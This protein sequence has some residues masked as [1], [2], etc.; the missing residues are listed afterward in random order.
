MELE[1]SYFYSFTL[2]GQRKQKSSKR[3]QKDVQKMSKLNQ[4]LSSGNTATALAYCRKE[5]PS[6][7]SLGLQKEGEVIPVLPLTP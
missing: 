6:G 2:I 1:S 3:S 5:P 7:L 4:I